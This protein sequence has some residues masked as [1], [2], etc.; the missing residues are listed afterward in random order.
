MTP[1]TPCAVDGVHALSPDG[2]PFVSKFRLGF[3]TT[4]QTSIAAFLRD[5]PGAANALSRSAVR[6][7]SAVTA[8]EGRLEAVNSW[9]GAFLSFGIMQWTAGVA[10]DPGELAALLARVRA[11]D[12][13][14][15]KECFGRFG[16]DLAIGPGALTG[17]LTI[18]GAA[19]ANS[20]DKAPL[21]TAQWAYRFWRA[22]HHPLVRRCQLAHAAARIDRFSGIKVRGHPIREWLSSELGMAQVLDQHVNRP[23]HVPDTLDRALGALISAGSLG[24]DPAGWKQADEQKL[25]ERYLALRAKTSMTSSQARANRLFDL[26]RTGSLDIA[27]G[28]FS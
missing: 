17:R 12:A 13:E 6:A 19:L 10:G 25:I 28:S 27:R 24:P 20:R 11:A 8:N 15:F 2:K 5:D 21:R 4:G 16:L 1:G 7:V 18:G 26:A 14:V 22:G 9:D 23:G 3:V